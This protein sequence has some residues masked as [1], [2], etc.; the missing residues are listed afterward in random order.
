MTSGCTDER[1]RRTHADLGAKLNLGREAHFYKICKA[2]P[3][4]EE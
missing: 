1:E 3:M 4:P 2:G